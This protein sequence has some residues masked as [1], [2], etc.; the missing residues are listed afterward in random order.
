MNEEIESGC[1]SVVID[2]LPSVKGYKCE[3]KLHLDTNLVRV[4]VTHEE[5]GIS[6]GRYIAW[7]EIKISRHATLAR[8][9]LKYEVSKAIEQI[10]KILNGD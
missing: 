10:D 3:F 8:D 2:L 9:Y 4:D 5:S 6:S 7:E 1:T